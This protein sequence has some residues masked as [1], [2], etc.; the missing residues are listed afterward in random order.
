[1]VI[2]TRPLPDTLAFATRQ[3]RAR[4]IL[5]RLKPPPGDDAVARKLLKAAW[6]RTSF[7]TLT[8]ASATCTPTR[9]VAGRQRSNGR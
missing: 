5:N 3:A 4:Y 1:V 7:W 9:R 8:K 2:A 6:H